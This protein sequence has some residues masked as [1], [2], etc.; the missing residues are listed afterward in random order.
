MDDVLRIKLRKYDKI[1][2]MVSGLI[3]YR[4]TKIG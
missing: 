4:I 1:S 3:N 2:V